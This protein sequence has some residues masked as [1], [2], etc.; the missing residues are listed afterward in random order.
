[1]A[2]FYTGGSFREEEAEN[3]LEIP[4]IFYQ[5]YVTIHCTTHIMSKFPGA[6]L[7]TK[8]TALNPSHAGFDHPHKRTTHT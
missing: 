3:S 2:V 5:T 1:M 7:L 8:L 4:P 6:Y